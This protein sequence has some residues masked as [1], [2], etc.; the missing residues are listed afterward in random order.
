VKTDLLRVFWYL[1]IVVDE[2]SRKV[3]AWRVSRSLTHTEAL[4]LLDDGIIGERLLEMPE[5]ARL[6]VVCLAGSEAY[7]TS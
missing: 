5:D 2:W 6:V 7:R 3:M 1:Y 4:G